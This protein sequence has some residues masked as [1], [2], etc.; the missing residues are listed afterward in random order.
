MHGSATSHRRCALIQPGL[1]AL[2]RFEEDALWQEFYTVALQS[3]EDRGLIAAKRGHVAVLDRT[4]LETMA[5]D[6]YG[7]PEAEYTRLI[8]LPLS[9]SSGHKVQ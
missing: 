6:S 1:G 3:F 5:R 7:L 8:G 9:P 2:C 4:K